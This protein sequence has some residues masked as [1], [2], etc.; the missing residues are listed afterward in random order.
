MG[1]PP[2]TVVG[3]HPDDKFEILWEPIG[4]GRCSPLK[5]IVVMGTNGTLRLPFRS[6]AW[7]IE[8]IEKLMK[9][10][11]SVSRKM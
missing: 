11:I 2:L 1:I 6:G 4:K 7:T 8:K 5:Q 3:K 9:S 10:K